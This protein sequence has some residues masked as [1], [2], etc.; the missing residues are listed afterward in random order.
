MKDAERGPLNYLGGY[1]LR[2]LYRKH[3]SKAS[4]KTKICQEKEEFMALLDSLHVNETVAKDTAFISAKDRGGL[5]YPKEYLTD[6][7]VTAEIQLRVHT[8]KEVCHKICVDK[9]VDILLQNPVLRS[10]WNMLVEE[11]AC[12]ITR[13]RSIIFLDQILS[14]FIKIRSFS[15]AKDIVQKYKIQQKAT[16]KKGLRKEIKRATNPNVQL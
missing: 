9:I 7:F 4:K 13:G 6:I 3:L 11:C 16:K 2:N 12:E 14:L 5:W 15:Y 1:I 8:G 10:K